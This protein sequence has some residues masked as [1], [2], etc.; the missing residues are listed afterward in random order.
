MTDIAQLAYSVDSSGLA[1]GTQQLDKHTVSAQKTEAATQKT[2]A[3]TA[4]FDRQ[5]QKLAVSQKQLSMANRQLPMQF[6]DIAVSLQAGMNPM[7]VMLQQGSQIKDMYG[8]LGPALRASAGYIM[9]LVNPYTVAAAAVAGLVLAYSQFEERQNAIDRALIR[10]GKYT[11]E[12]A[13]QLR[14]LSRDMDAVAGVTAGSAAKAI[15]QVAS[16]GS[17]TKEQLEIVA[18]AAETW[19]AATGDAIEDTVKDFEKLKKDPVKAALELNRV[20][21][22]LTEAT[23]EQILAFKEQGREIDATELLIRELAGTLESRAPRM[24][25]EVGEITKMFRYLK[26]EAKEAWDVVVE[27]IG[28]GIGAYRQWLAEAGR[29]PADMLD[30]VGQVE[31]RIRKLSQMKFGDGFMDQFRQFAFGDSIDAELKKAVARRNELLKPAATPESAIDSDAAE[32]AMKAREEWDRLTLSNLSKQEKLEREIADIRKRGLAAGKSEADIQAAIA[33]AR[34]RYAESLAKGRKETD[35]TEALIKRLREQ[36]ALNQE[37]LQ[38]EDKLTATERML[39]QVRTELDRIGAKGSAQ[40]KALIAELMEQ[41]KA[42]DAAVQ[43][44]ERQ[45]KAEES[46]AR[47]RERTGLAEQ[48]QRRSNEV[49]LA[50][51]SRGSEAAEMLRRQLDLHR[52]YEDQVSDLA[53]QAAREKRDITLEEEQELKDSL[54]RQLDEERRYQ[55]QRKL[56]MADWRAGATRALEDYVSYASDLNGQAYEMLGSGIGTLEDEIVNLTQTG[57][58]EWESM[59]ESWAEMATRFATRQIFAGFIKKFF[60]D[61]GGDNEAAAL[62]KS[63]SELAASGMT[64]VGAAGALSASAAA[65]AAAGLAG[66]GSGGAGGSEGSFYGSL[67]SGLAGLYGGGREGG[68]DVYGG[69]FYRVGER[70]KPELLNLGGNAQFLIPGDRGRVEPMEEEYAEMSMG[71]VTQHIYV[72]GRMTN[73]TARQTQ[74]EAS[75]RQ[76]IATA[77]FGG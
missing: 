24:R 28:R 23:W 36:I 38:S 8:G 15:A 9:G 57:R 6:T 43:A 45:L 69:Q 5:V 75:R 39:V 53:R 52:W 71:P 54:Q 68:G 64:L 29:L 42:T 19:R 51:M 60:P 73:D 72:Q 26:E 40:N 77:R 13:E 76:R 32:Q 62:S 58:F 10:S 17:F 66:G 21:G 2:E 20:Y 49:D 44:S 48:N 7:Q 14:D 46:L 3:A 34:A 61:L 65:L 37:Q 16:V 59:L 50:G 22:F 63:A 25:D 18:R 11:E 70:N 74:I 31:T 30:E 33:N 1:R 12:Y 55:E 47:L 41:A 27:G 35:P 56:L 67:I 4:K